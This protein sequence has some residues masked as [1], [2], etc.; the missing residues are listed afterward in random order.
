MASIFHHG[1]ERVAP[2]HRIVACHVERCIE[3]Y[4]VVRVKSSSA[5]EAEIFY[6]LAIPMLFQSVTGIGC[7]KNY[8]FL[9]SCEE[10]MPA[11]ELLQSGWV[12]TNST[13]DEWIAQTPMCDHVSKLAQ[14]DANYFTNCLWDLND[15]QICRCL[16]DVTLPEPAHP[17]S[18]IAET[19]A[20][21]L[22]SVS[23]NRNN[24][25]RN[26]VLATSSKIFQCLDCSGPMKYSCQHCKFFNHWFHR[27]CNDPPLKQR[28]Q[29]F[30]LK[31]EVPQTRAQ[32]ARS[33]AQAAWRNVVRPMLPGQPGLNTRSVPLVKSLP[34]E[35]LWPP[36]ASVDSG[37]ADGQEDASPTNILGRTTAFAQE[38]SME[39]DGVLVC[40]TPRHQQ[41][42]RDLGV[43]EGQ[44]V[45]YQTL[46]RAFI[47][48]IQSQPLALTN[49]CPPV[50]GLPL[51]SQPY[52]GELDEDEGRLEAI[53]IRSSKKTCR[54]CLLEKAAEA[55]VV[56]PHQHE[57]LSDNC[58]SCIRLLR[59]QANRSWETGPAPLAARGNGPRPRAKSGQKQ[60]TTGSGKSRKGGP[61][62]L[63]SVLE[64]R[65]S[66]CAVVKPASGF[67]RNSAD[68]TGLQ[69]WCRACCL[70]YGPRGGQRASI[71]RTQQRSFGYLHQPQVLWQASQA[72]GGQPLGARLQRRLDPADVIPMVGA[73]RNGAPPSTGGID[74]TRNEPALLLEVPGGRER[75]NMAASGDRWGCEVSHKDQGQREQ[76]GNPGA[77][78]EGAGLSQSP[79]CG[80]QNCI[81][82]GMLEDGDVPGDDLQQ[83]ILMRP[84]GHGSVVYDLG[85]EP[86]A[87]VGQATAS[88]PLDSGKHQC[89][90]V[91]RQR[92]SPHGDQ[93]GV[94]ALG[95]SCQV[96]IVSR[97]DANHREF[98]F[99]SEPA[100]MTQSVEL[101]WGDGHS[102]PSPSQ[103]GAFTDRSPANDRPSRLPE[104]EVSEG[105][106][107]WPGAVDVGEKRGLAGSPESRASPGCRDSG[108]LSDG[109]KV[110][111]GGGGAGM[112]LGM[113]PTGGPSQRATGAQKRKP[114]VV[115]RVLNA[116][117]AEGGGNGDSSAAQ[118][119]G[120][121]VGGPLRSPKRSATD[122]HACET[123]PGKRARLD[124]GGD[125]SI[126][127][128]NGQENA[129]ENG[130]VTPGTNETQADAGGAQRE[131][132]SCSGSRCEPIDPCQSRPG[133]AAAA[134]RCTKCGACRSGGEVLE[135]SWW[136]HSCAGTHGP[137]QCVVCREFKS[138][139]HF[140][141]DR[142]KPR[143]LRASCLECEAS[144]RPVQAG[145][146]TREH[147]GGAPRPGGAGG[148]ASGN[149]GVGPVLGKGGAGREERGGVFGEQENSLA[150]NGVAGG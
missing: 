11:W 83:R 127:R 37:Q 18:L 92:L 3:C 138:P 148:G 150:V 16:D 99:S 41:V 68:T 48:C 26:T 140:S 123:A 38:D 64:K 116:G 39:G 147:A 88:L 59:Q 27:D 113:W 60:W 77:G 54:C 108:G 146:G 53:P 124:S 129:R 110:A 133:P 74:L 30:S 36:A 81:S 130:R 144:G 82:A 47:H 22:V 121:G 76:K 8:V 21:L 57:G 75:A 93:I 112:S 89:L 65:C 143:R 103:R 32:V 4:A 142:R 19:P 132:P 90:G 126:A 13:Y 49:Q 9:C 106:S 122:P 119:G 134:R 114:K 7:A 44:D 131:R 102:G 29:G 97:P 94:Q 85:A 107:R 69:E 43:L 109:L 95:P 86:G 35:V 23:L 104:S 24:Y 91:G 118:G 52:T 51:I 137:R 1:G 84:G 115:N 40:S 128:E 31:S 25:P 2:H 63:P 62:H 45:Q 5:E 135:G 141:R 12:S 117:R 73:G 56:D 111:A 42:G 100:L 105:Q 87:Q 6:V 78:F 61:R 14:I 70:R 96:Q 67:Y 58:L 17:I 139:S 80:T 79:L 149:K 55:F 20:G 66:K 120:E 125:G 46:S 28:L 72:V 145:Q 98:S 101:P 50:L 136:C 10:M 15:M 71:E 34:E 33:V